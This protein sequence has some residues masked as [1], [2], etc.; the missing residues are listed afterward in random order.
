MELMAHGVCL[1][2]GD[3]SAVNVGLVFLVLFVVFSL[4]VKHK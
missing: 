4:V 2:S 1:V 3:A